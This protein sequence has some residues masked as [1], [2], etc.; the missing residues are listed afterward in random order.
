MGKLVC[1]TGQRWRIFYTTAFY[2]L[3]EDG[4]ILCEKREDCPEDIPDQANNTVLE[5]RCSPRGSVAEEE[6]PEDPSDNE[7]LIIVDPDFLAQ[8]ICAEK[9]VNICCTKFADPDQCEGLDKENCNEDTSE[10][11][12]GTKP[13]IQ[14]ATPT[15]KVGVTVPP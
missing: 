10:V 14:I 3:Q 9:T 5:F 6:D 13:P 1:D 2:D 8:L 4:S 7:L 12:G 11:Y 15:E